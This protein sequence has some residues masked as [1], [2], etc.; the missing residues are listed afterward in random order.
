MVFTSWMW[1]WHIY[2][3][4]QWTETAHKYSYLLYVTNRSESV[5]I[6]QR[7]QQASSIAS[8]QRSESEIFSTYG[9][10]EFLV[11]SLKTLNHQVK[12][13]STFVFPAWSNSDRVS[14]KV[15]EWFQ[16]ELLFA[17]AHSQSERNIRL[18]KE[19]LDFFMELFSVLVKLHD[20]F[21]FFSHPEFIKLIC[22]IA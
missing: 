19:S 5:L 6:S 13:P 16:S 21:G 2:L 18:L 22:Q 9:G 17:R 12:D 1:C 4:T 10:I 3:L 7:R 15:R 11:H 8:P 20:A 14:G